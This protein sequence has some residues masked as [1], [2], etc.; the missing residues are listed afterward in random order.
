MIKFCSE[1]RACQNTVVAI[2]L[3][4]VQQ[5]QNKQQQI[6]LRYI[7]GNFIKFEAE[8]HRFHTIKDKGGESC[9]GPFFHPDAGLHTADMKLDQNTYFS[10][11][12]IYLFPLNQINKQF[13]SQATGNVWFSNSWEKLL[14]LLRSRSPKYEE[15]QIFNVFFWMGCLS[16][17]HILK[18]F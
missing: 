12:N 10:S 1:K 2:E 8:V 6:I 18:H 16:I 14:A 9:R 17:V 15:F 13:A 4:Q 3:N 7:L 5:K 11:H